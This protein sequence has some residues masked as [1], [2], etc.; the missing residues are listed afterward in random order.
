MYTTTSAQQI[1]SVVSSAYV[2]EHHNDDLQGYLPAR[3][4]EGLFDEILK[5]LRGALSGCR[6][7]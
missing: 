6:R 3:E 1:F 2:S 4:R 5:A 7:H